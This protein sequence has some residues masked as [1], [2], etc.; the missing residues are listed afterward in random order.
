MVIDSKLN[1]SHLGSNVYLL[2]RESLISGKLK[3]NDRLKIRELAEQFGTSV[4]PVRDAILQLSK[5]HALVM[6]SPRDIRV[7]VLTRQQYLE[8]RSLRIELEGLA[9]YTAAKKATSEKLELLENN[10]NE[11]LLAIHEKD[12]GKSLVL[13]SAFHIMLAS[14]AE[15]P[16]LES[17]IS[18][19]WMRT[20]GVVAIAYEHFSEEMA[21][22]HHWEVLEALKNGDSEIA[23]YAIHSDI[24]NGNQIMARYI[25]L[26]G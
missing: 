11:N 1:N 18:T 19:L 6:K 21:I 9:A 4:T 17:F 26:D 2:L 7:P 13:N 14:I 23:K 24:Y 15:M 8:N 12:I 20:G 22:H 16:L 5:E 10:I 3:P 25:E